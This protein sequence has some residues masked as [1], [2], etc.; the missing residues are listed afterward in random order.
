MARVLSMNADRDIHA[1]GG[2]LQIAVGLD[3]ILQNCERA[4]R[5]RFRE[6]IYA[7]NRG[8]DYF[9]Y[10]Y[11]PSP[12]VIRFEAGARA[13]LAR[14]QG[15]ISI[16]GFTAQIRSARMEYTATIRTAFGTGIVSNNTTAGASV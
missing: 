16:D 1:V 4:I 14:V 5:A 6:M 2:R 11:G 15:V 8:V 10:V 12:D 9:N 7:N 3:A 13:Q